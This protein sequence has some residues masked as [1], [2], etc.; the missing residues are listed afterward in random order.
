[1]NRRSFLQASTA[2]SLLPLWPSGLLPRSSI[3]RVR[4]SD[5]HW[6]SKEAWKRLNDAVGGKLIGVDFPLNACKSSPESGDCKTLFTNLRNPYYI[7]DQPGLTQTLGWVGAWA[8]KPSVYAVVARNAND[9]SAAVNFARENDLRLVIKGGGHSYQGTSNAPDSLLVW[10]RH[11]HDIAMHGAF[12][13]QGCEYPSTATGRDGGRWHDRDAGL[14]G[15]YHARR[16]ICSGRWMHHCGPC[17]SGSGW[18]LRKLFEALWNGRGELA[19]SRSCHCRRPDS[20]RECMHQSGPVLGAKRRR[21]RH[22]RR[23]QQNDLTSSRSSRVLRRRSF[24]DQS[25]YR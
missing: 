19:R 13:P 7:G 17:G 5:P 20:D 3:R 1:M 24:Q 21:G 23:P 6:P 14:P 12:V 4:P 22:L 15:C 25:I 16:E 18:R 9:I 8:T 2:A 11:M 10:T